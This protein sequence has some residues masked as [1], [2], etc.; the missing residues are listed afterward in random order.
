MDKLASINPLEARKLIRNNKITRVTSGIAKGYVQ[1]NLVVIKKD[2]A[3]DFLLFCIRNSK[4]C[5]V[6]DVTELGNPT[7]ELVAPNADI[8]TDI[9]KYRVYKDGE[10][11]NQ[12]SHIKDYWTEDMIAF[13]IGC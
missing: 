6:L 9:P 4:T 10:L 13:L 3:Y 2:I 12:T 8:R 5:P 11:I 1:A 7:P